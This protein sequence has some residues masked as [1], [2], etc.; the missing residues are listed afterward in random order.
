MQQSNQDSYDPTLKLGKQPIQ[1]IK[2]YEEEFVEGVKKVVNE[3]FSPGVPFCPTTVTSRC[4]KCPFQ[5]LCT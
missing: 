1:D 3:I 4:T 5:Q 2:V